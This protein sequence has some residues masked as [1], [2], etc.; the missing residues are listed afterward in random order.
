M[1]FDLDGEL[2]RVVRAV[3]KWESRVFGEI[4]K[5][6]WELVETCFGFHQLYPRVAQLNLMLVPQLLVEV[7]QFRSKYSRRT[8]SAVSIG[9]RWMLRVP[10]R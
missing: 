3:G 1:E 2:A 4:S 5:G 7:P 8:S 9:I 10:F 6:V